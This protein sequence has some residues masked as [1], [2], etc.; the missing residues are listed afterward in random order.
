M[1]LCEPKMMEPGRGSSST[2]RRLPS[3]N[4]FS[5]LKRWKRKE[6]WMT[7]MRPRSSVRV[8]ANAT[9][10]GGPESI[11]AVRERCASSNASPARNLTGKDAGVVLNNLCPRSQNPFPRENVIFAR[12][13]HATSKNHTCF[14]VR[15][16][17]MRHRSP[18]TD[19]LSHLN[20]HY[21]KLSTGL[22]RQTSRMS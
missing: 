6:A 20:T 5:S 2:A 17:G 8:F 22:S 16:N 13:V 15:R 18:V 1:P 14:E 9:G 19:N 3:S 10:G 11:G 4:C 7:E 12:R 21:T